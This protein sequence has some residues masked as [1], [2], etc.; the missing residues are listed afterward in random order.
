MVCSN[1]E[2]VIARVMLLYEN[3]PPEIKRSAGDAYNPDSQI[4]FGI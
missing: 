3:N 1:F 4:N 2:M